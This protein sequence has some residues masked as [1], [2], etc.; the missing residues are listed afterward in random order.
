ME[1]QS[2]VFFPADREIDVCYLDVVYC[3]VELV[4]AVEVANGEPYLF[5]YV[6]FKVYRIEVP[7]AFFSCLLL[8]LTVH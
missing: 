4:V 8:S 7:C 6:F 2:K 1:F 5:T 3:E